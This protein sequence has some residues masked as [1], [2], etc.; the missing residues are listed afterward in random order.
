M[1]SPLNLDEVVSLHTT[2]TIQHTRHTHP[3]FDYSLIEEDVTELLASDAYALLDRFDDDE[4]RK[5]GD[6]PFGDG[7]LRLVIRDL[8]LVTF[9]KLN[10][11]EGKGGPL[12]NCNSLLRVDLTGCLSLTTLGYQLFA[13]CRFLQ[14]VTEC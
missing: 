14:Q 11:E 12:V 4:R 7:T 8:R 5:R 2:H 3:S 9:G 1:T 13:N 6:D 10:I